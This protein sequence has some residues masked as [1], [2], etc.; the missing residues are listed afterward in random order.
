MLAESVGHY[1][2]VS[3]LSVYADRSKPMVERQR[4]R[5][6]RRRCPT[7]ACSRTTRTT[8]RS[9]RCASTPCR[10]VLPSSRVVRP[11]LIVGPHDPTGRF[12]YWP[13]RVARGGEVL[14]PAPPEDRVQFID[15]RDLANWMVGLCE[16]KATAAS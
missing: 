1:L 10:D 8:A 2:F 11:G 12:T 16:R 13:H 14:G 7:T 15:V 4:A 6:A 3:S 5:G 9:R